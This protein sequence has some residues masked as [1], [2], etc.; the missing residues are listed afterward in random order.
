MLV[1]FH[2]FM[3]LNTHEVLDDSVKTSRCMGPIVELPD[4]PRPQ[5]PDRFNRQEYGVCV[6]PA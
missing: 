1:L 6:L 5:R 2:L 3:I 4:L